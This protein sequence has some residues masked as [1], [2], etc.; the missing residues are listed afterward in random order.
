[1]QSSVFCSILYGNKEKSKFILF[2]SDFPKKSLH[3]MEND[4]ELL[5]IKENNICFSFSKNYEPNKTVK[6]RIFEWITTKILRK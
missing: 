2:L 4:R 1:M 5:D 3:W 6:Y